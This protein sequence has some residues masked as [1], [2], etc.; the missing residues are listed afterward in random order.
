MHNFL[1]LWHS[2]VMKVLWVYLQRVFG[3]YYTGTL[4]KSFSYSSFFFFSCVVQVFS[5]EREDYVTY[6]WFLALSTCKFN[7]DLNEF[8][9]V[10]R[11]WKLIIFQCCAACVSFSPINIIHIATLVTINLHFLSL[12]FEAKN[13]SQF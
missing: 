12:R 3:Q 7:F 11:N 13:H 9:S 5:W 2:K 1:Q 4:L 8:Q 6:W 10:A